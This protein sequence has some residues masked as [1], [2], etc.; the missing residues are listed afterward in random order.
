[1]YEGTESMGEA[2]EALQ[3][4]LSRN[5]QFFM[6]MSGPTF[7]VE[8]VSNGFIVRI[9]K[10]KKVPIPVHDPHDDP[11]LPANRPKIYDHAAYEEKY[12]CRLL[13]EVETL[14]WGHFVTVAERAKEAKRRANSSGRL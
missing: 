10:I 7:A 4:E 6:N 13:S 1:M 14:L 12:V 8:Q 5:A 9:R 2:E 3:E 11:M